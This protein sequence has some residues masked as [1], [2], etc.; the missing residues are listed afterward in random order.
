ML[1]ASGQITVIGEAEDGGQAAELAHALRPDVVLMDLQ[2]PKVNGLEGLRRIHADNSELPVVIL[3]TFQT[4]ESV[5]EALNAGAKGF[6]LKDAGGAE[7][8]AAVLAAQRGETTFASSVTER[9]AALATG[10]ATKNGND[11]SELN[12]REREVL[13]QLVRGARN[14]EIAAELF[15]TTKTV[16]YH[17]SNIFAKLG[18]SNRTEAVR[19]ALQNGMT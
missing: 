8:I 5:S 9:L 4:D 11:L 10:Q 19:V 7:I 12:E 16:E 15:I 6:L 13:Q 17:L 1:E 2:M 18:V 3:T 14:K